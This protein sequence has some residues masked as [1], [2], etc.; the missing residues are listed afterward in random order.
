[1]KLKIGL[2][3]LVATIS[4][5]GASNIKS[6]T[7]KSCH[8]KIYDEY[9]SSA[10]H[11]SYLNHDKLFKAVWSKAP[12][13]KSCLKCHV[14][15]TKQNPTQN[16]SIECIG[17]H[18]IKAIKHG[19]ISNSN[20]YDNRDK[21]FYSAQESERGE[22]LNYQHKR[23]NW[24]GLSSRRSG[25]PYHTIDYSNDIFYNGKVCMGCHSHKK[26]AN[27]L[28]LCS[29]DIKDMNEKQNCITC[30]MPNVTGSAT[31]IRI[32]KMHKFH[33][34]AGSRYAQNVLSKY[35]DMSIKP[36]PKSVE[37][38]IKN[39]APH[40]LLTHPMRVLI[41]KIN[42]YKD[43]KK[44]YSVKKSFAR[45]VGKD[46]KPSAPWL[47]TEIVRDDMIKAKENRVVKIN[48]PTNITFDKSEALLG[49]YL[50]NPKMAKKL[51]IKDKEL[52]KLHI[53]KRVVN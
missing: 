37:V 20:I 26:N 32:S 15:P 10:H 16:S 6:S 27:G 7:C 41:L 12:K 1:M 42:L 4:S 25:S 30:H 9:I 17:C 11:L 43:G 38:V 8:P 21:Y 53:L 40:S 49:Y 2:S 5:I 18:K 50:V 39:K 13:K 45:I 19:N 24:F 14:A 48:I 46:G 22:K 34:F 31:T 47:A 44:V 23:T 35:I 29:T 51:G 52:L 28:T 33:G 36:S 3:I